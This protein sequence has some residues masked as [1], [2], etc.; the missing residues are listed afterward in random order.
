LNFN[1]S[2]KYSLFKN[3]NNL[4]A[5]LPSDEIVEDCKKVLQDYLD[6]LAEIKRSYPEIPW[7]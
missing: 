5:L 4:S 2:G 3:S 7:K 6:E 1:K